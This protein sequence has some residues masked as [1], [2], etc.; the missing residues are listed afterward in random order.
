MTMGLSE[1]ARYDERGG[2]GDPSSCAGHAVPV[3]QDGELR[4]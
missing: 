3:E 1:C 4:A 2:R